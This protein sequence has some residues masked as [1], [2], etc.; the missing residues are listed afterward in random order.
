MILDFFKELEI[1]CL[2]MENKNKLLWPNTKLE[3]TQNW[4]KSK[5]GVQDDINIDGS[6]PKIIC[7]SIQGL[8]DTKKINNNFSVLDICCGDAL[9]LH[10][11]KTTYKESNVIGFDI[12]KGKL[13]SHQEAEQIG[14]NLFFGYIQEL[15]Q[16]DLNEK[17]DIVI[18]LN[19]FRAWDRAQLREDEGNLPD[20]ANKWMLKNARYLLLTVNDRQLSL[21]NS[22]F[23]V[24]ILGRGEEISKFILV[25]NP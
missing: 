11:I 16:T 14:V 8:I 9:I 20:M 4:I 7:D 24:R 5:Y 12:N 15:F 18:M 2:G 10:Q 22:K 17:I 13:K 1:K 25:E 3:E 6:R 23:K 19:T 21:F